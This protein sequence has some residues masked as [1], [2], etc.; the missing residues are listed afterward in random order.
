MTKK[1]RI[2][3]ADGSDHR[4]VVQT[5]QK[6]VDG[7]PD[8]LLKEEPLRNP[9]DML[10]GWVWQGQ[11]LIVVE[12]AEG[13]SLCLDGSDSTLGYAPV[14]TAEKVV[15]LSQG[16]RLALEILERLKGVRAQEAVDVLEWVSSMIRKA[17]LGSSVSVDAAIEHDLTLTQRL[18]R[19]IN[20][21]LHGFLPPVRT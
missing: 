12:K 15:R 17:S 4:V 21:E 16:E 7:A 9:T 19:E 20:Q 6:G 3:N 10:D 8:V 1:I 13:Y 2:E 14:E 18:R 11:Y 5:W